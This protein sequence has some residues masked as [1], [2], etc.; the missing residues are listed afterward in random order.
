M[1]Q[2]TIEVIAQKGGQSQPFVRI[3]AMF[4]QHKN[5]LKAVL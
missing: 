4:L 1:C 2:S 5:L 3:G